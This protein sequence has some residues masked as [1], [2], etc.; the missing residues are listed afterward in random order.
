[1][2]CV[3]NNC[4][5][6]LGGKLI[7]FVVCTINAQ[8]ALQKCPI[9]FEMPCSKKGVCIRLKTEEGTLWALNINQE[10]LGLMDWTSNKVEAQ[11]ILNK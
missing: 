2:R 9:R 8:Y 3:I 11:K 5:F 6:Y 7:Q 4:N 1:M 10:E